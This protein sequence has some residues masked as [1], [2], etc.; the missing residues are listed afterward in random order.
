MLN[1]DYNEKYSCI[2]GLLQY[3]LNIIATGCFDKD[4]EYIKGIHK[5][6]V[7]FLFIHHWNRTIRLCIPCTLV[8]VNILCVSMSEI[9]S[10]DSKYTIWQCQSYTAI[11]DAWT[12]ILLALQCD[13]DD[14]YDHLS[15]DVNHIANRTLKKNYLT[16]KVPVTSESY[17]AS[18]LLIL[19]A[20]IE[21]NIK[22]NIMV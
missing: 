14:L 15:F 18:S 4:Q 21:D 13:D 16:F 9:H 3:S 20:K 1:S 19:E 6:M 8:I 22:L 11:T 2:G 10:L 17:T 12:G 5:R 7:W